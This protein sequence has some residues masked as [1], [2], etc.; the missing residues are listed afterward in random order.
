M[1]LNYSLGNKHSKFWIEHMNRWTHDNNNHQ[2]T[3]R[4]LQHKKP[5]K[6]IQENR[7]AI[8]EN[9]Y[10]EILQLVENVTQ[11]LNN[12]FQRHIIQLRYDFEKFYGFIQ[13]FNFEYIIRHMISNVYVLSTQYLNVHYEK[14][15]R[16]FGKYKK[17]LKIH[18]RK[19]QQLVEELLREYDF[20]Q[21]IRSEVNTNL[22]W[23][24][25]SKYLEHIRA[26]RTAPMFRH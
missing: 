19:Y 2:R 5:S 17:Q 13:T 10:L 9:N 15:D 21:K 7:Q 23:L 6:L 26:R 12:G 4:E 24:P 20:K 1:N 22:V 8:E 16:L 3:L 11:N 18:F 25:H 14:L